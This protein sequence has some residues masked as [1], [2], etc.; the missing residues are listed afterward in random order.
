[1]RYVIE[2]YIE[3]EG[4]HDLYRSEVFDTPQ[5]AHADLEDHLERMSAGGRMIQDIDN[6]RVS[7]I[8]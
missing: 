5:E 7:E 1:M 2:T 4:W 3:D 8:L 6:Y